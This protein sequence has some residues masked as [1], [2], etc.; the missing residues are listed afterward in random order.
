MS[1]NIKAYFDKLYIGNIEF[2][3]NSNVNITGSVS[4]S[5]NLIVGIGSYISFNGSNNVSL[6]GIKD[7]NGTLKYKNS[8][9]EWRYFSTIIN[10]YIN[11]PNENGVYPDNNLVLQEAGFGLRDNNGVLEFKNRTGTA[12]TIWTTIGTDQIVPTTINTLTCNADYDFSN[13]KLTN[14]KDPTSNQDASTKKYTDD[15][16][17]LV[18]VPTT[19]NTLTCNADYNFSNNKIFNLKDPVNLQD[20]ATKKYIDQTVFNAINSYLINGSIQIQKLLFTGTGTKVLYDDG[21][22]KEISTTPA[23][24]PYTGSLAGVNAKLLIFGH[25][26]ENQASTNVISNLHSVIQSLNG[27]VSN[28]LLSSTGIYIN[29][30]RLTKDINMNTILTNGYNSNYDAILY[31]AY[32]SADNNPTTILNNWYDNN[33]GVILGINAMTT[34]GLNVSKMIS[35][36]GA[37]TNGGSS[38]YTQSSN[39]PILLGV[40]N[41]SPVWYSKTLTTINPALGIGNIDGTN[42]VNYLDD[43]TGKGR[44]VDIN[45]YPVSILQSDN[46]TVSGTRCILQS[47]LWAARK[48]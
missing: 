34:G 14:V 26:P 11:F 43:T 30:I 3:P 7:D 24:I 6:Y 5:N 21:T 1:N 17:N 48:I 4:I 29:H 32:S 15:K 28:D 20:A 18:V 16:F 33:K 25:I 31:Y 23:V 2:D 46:T 40:N 9:G 44:R 10:G 45:L 42:A 47:L 27:T 8:T 39:H 22:F 41:I 13:F 19:I 38:S 36:Y 35:N 12:N 37:E